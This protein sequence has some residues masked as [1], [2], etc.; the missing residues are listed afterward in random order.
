MVELALPV[1]SCQRARAIFQ[2]TIGIHSVTSRGYLYLIWK[3]AM[4]GHQDQLK[5]RETLLQHPKLGWDCQHTVRS[6]LGMEPWHRPD[7]EPV[8]ARMLPESMVTRMV[9]G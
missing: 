1:I 8:P 9:T 6:L 4:E 3:P 7:I 2:V 5:S